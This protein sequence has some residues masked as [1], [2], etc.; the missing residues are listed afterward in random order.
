MV[1]S[2]D[3]QT[4]KVWDLE[5]GQLLH[6]LLGHFDAVA[7]CAITPDGRRVVSAS[8]DHTLKLW[9][10]ESGQH[11]HTFQGHS[12][13]VTGSVLTPDG[14]RVISSSDDRTLK[15]WDL[16]RQVLLDTLYGVA[17]FTC[18]ATGSGLIFA[19]DRL[20]NVWILEA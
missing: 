14:R 13:V 2:S 11:L 18:V 6:T 5:S 16:E 1:S 20:G 9:D 7:S 4:V 12:D 10:L 8:W 19:G 17:P 15:L 3:D